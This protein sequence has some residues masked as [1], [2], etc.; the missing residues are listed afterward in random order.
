MREILARGWSTSLIMEDDVDWDI[1][2]RHQLSL[3]APMIQKVTN[4][5]N[6]DNSPY[7]DGWDLLWLGHCGETTPLSGPV[8]S[9]ID[10][11][12]P[13]S[14]IYR[15]YDGT[16]SYFPPQMRI[17]HYTYRPICTYAYA[18]TYHGASIIYQSALGGSDRTITAGL[19]ENCM[20]GL[21]RCVSV[22]PELFHHHKKEGVSTSQ[23]AVLEGWDAMAKPA[24][25][26]F[27]ANI[28]HSAR[29]NSGSETLVTCQDPMVYQ[30]RGN[31]D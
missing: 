4:S 12:L 15:M 24:D 8:I 14:P 1:A 22:N 2:I 17:V 28:R 20:K 18:V 30:N 11:S 16:H 31:L 6:L 9:Q 29:C 25:V 7:G 10:E 23:I 27:T 13:E 3:V 19:Y 26:T 21:L 5:T